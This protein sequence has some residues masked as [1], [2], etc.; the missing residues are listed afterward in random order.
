MTAAAAEPPQPDDNDAS[1]EIFGLPRAAPQSKQPVADPLD[2]AVTEFL[3]ALRAGRQPSIDEFASRFPKRATEVR[4]LLSVAAAMES[5]KIG[6]EQTRA[7]KELPTTDAS[8]P[9]IG[10]CRLIR[11]LGRGGMGVV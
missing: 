8:L 9:D 4:D 5:W 7:L 10:G 2:L 3:D 6:K 11:E 1:A